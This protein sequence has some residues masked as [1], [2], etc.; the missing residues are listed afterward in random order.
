MA[1]RATETEYE[2]SVRLLEEQQQEVNSTKKGLRLVDEQLVLLKNEAV[3]EFSP[4]QSD[5]DKL[6]I[7]VYVVRKYRLLRTT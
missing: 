2:L 7:Q 1:I 4:I 3:F 6:T 5:A